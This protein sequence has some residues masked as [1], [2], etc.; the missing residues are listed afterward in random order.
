MSLKYRTHGA[1]FPTHIG[2]PIPKE[3]YILVL[4][5]TKLVM[6]AIMYYYHYYYHHCN[7]IKCYWIDL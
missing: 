7:N 1:N 3:K 2:D 6:K 5:E 4:R